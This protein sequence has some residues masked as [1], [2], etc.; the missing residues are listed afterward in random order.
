MEKL[1]IAV[2][3]VFA[4]LLGSMPSAIWVGRGFYGVDVREHGSGNAGATNTFRV[5]GKRAGIMVL[6]L[7]VLK[8]FTA[9]CLVKLLASVAPDSVRYVN[10]QLLFGMTAVLGH[11]FPIYE[12]FKGG[13]G[14]ATLF[15]MII[16]IHYPLALVC[17]GFFLVV[18]LLTQ[19]V[20]LSSIMT[21][22][23]FPLFTI[24]VFQQKEKLF[25]AFGII[26]AVLVVLTH[27]KNIR[28]LISGNENKARI[29]KRS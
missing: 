14:I 6:L 15:G 3:T 11:V 1:I 28:K 21:A 18:L 19:Y 9:T 12:N 2:L 22:I 13:K 24:F 26:T 20:S 29:F 8:G 17:L 27:Q 10:L 5:L 16:A 4:Y 23:A 25:I 7:D